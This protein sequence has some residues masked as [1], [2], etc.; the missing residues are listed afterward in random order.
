LVAGTALRRA[1][2]N[3]LARNAAVVLGNRAAPDVVPVLSDALGGHVS[4]VVRGHAAWAL[5]RVGSD[6]ARRALVE[7]RGSE[8]D[9]AVLEEIGLA[10][11]PE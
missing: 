4:A 6:A 5:G 11:G 3:Q 1:S 7:A 8:S 2:R 10:L 9:A